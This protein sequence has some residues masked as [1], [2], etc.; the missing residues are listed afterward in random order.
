MTDNEA[1]D[2]IRILKERVDNHTRTLALLMEH[3]SLEEVSEKVVTE[4]RVVRKKK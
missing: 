4:K 2:Q 3:L 1:R